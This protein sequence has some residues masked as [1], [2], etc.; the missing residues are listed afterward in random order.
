MSE[1]TDV[2]GLVRDLA[3][4]LPLQARDALATALAAGTIAGPEGVALS[5][6]L[7]G[8]AEG[9]IRDFERVGARLA[10]LG[11]APKVRPAGV[12]VPPKWRDAMKA[13]AKAQR[14]TLEALVAAIPADADDAEGEAT[15]HLLEHVI[16]RKRDHVE[17]L[18]RALR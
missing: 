4:V 11:G 12:E 7:R 9:E 16:A 13:L 15:E 8:M 14:E 17:L 6:M 2:Q 10:T 5:A 18:E 3:R 1:Q